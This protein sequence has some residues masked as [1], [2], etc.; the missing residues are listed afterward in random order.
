MKRFNI[1]LTCSIF[2]PI[3]LS[4]QE[5]QS[6]VQ[7]KDSVTVSAGISKEQLDLEDRLDGVLARA[8]LALK[9]GNASDA[10][11]QYELA[12]ELANKEPLLIDQRERV[13]RRAGDAYLAANRPADAIAVYQKRLTIIEVDCAP[14]SNEVS[15][16]ASAQRELGIAKMRAHDF[17]GALAS[18][19]ATEGNY[20]RAEKA[21]DFHEISMIQVMEQAKT[22]VLLA[23]ALVQLGK[24]SEATATVQDAIPQFVRVK[25]DREIQAGIRESAASSLKDAQTLVARLKSAQ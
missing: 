17:E 18:F 11:K 12:L 10:V 13:L 9:G 7:R 1:L 22:K 5:K 4:S 20:A 14:D 8:E 23:V 6:S 25:D 3:L 15:T 16:C 21:S 2:I 19:R 24:S